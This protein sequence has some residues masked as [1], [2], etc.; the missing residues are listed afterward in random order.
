MCPFQIGHAD[1]QALVWPFKLGIRTA[2]LMWFLEFEILPPSLSLAGG[3]PE[4]H[5]HT[6]LWPLKLEMQTPTLHC[7]LQHLGR[8][9]VAHQLLDMEPH[10]SV[11]AFSWAKRLSRCIEAA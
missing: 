8:F 9:Y 5:P 2:I 6:S 11:L 10:T 3:A 1:S 7:G 4:F